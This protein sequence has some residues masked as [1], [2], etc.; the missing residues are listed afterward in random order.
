MGQ[1]SFHLL[2]EWN[3]KQRLL[4]IKILWQRWYFI[5]SRKSNKKEKCVGVIDN[6]KRSSNVSKLFSVW[7]YFHGH[8]RF[9]SQQGKVGDSF[10]YSS[11]NNLHPLT[12]LRWLR[13]I[14]NRIT[15]NCHA[16]DRCDLSNYRWG[17]H[18][19]ERYLQLSWWLN[20]WSY[21]S[22]IWTRNRVS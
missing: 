21:Y 13:S 2:L 7:V 18:L 14:F 11:L 4:T 5:Y 10:I 19:S 12:N 8:L 1:T 6:E 15:C 3:K 16:A 9:T 20:V 17:K 22:K